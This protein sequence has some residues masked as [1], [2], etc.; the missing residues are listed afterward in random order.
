MRCSRGW[1]SSGEVRP[2]LVVEASGG[3]VTDLKHLAEA[4]ALVWKEVLHSVGAISPAWLLAFFAFLQWRI[5]RSNLRLGLYGRR[6]EIYSAALDLKR[7]LDGFSGDAEGER[8]RKEVN[9][10][11]LTALRESRYL[12]AEKDQIGALLDEIWMISF[13]EYAW[14]IRCVNVKATEWV[15]DERDVAALSAEQADHEA[16]RRRLDVIFDQLEDRLEK[17]LSFGK[18]AP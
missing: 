11:F 7:W 9:G 2:W 12:F 18:I 4:A 14:R 8:I 3:A 13:R 10:R 15:G 17:Y 5:S 6:F 1:R 16:D